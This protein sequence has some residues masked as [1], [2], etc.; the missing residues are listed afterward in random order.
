MYDCETTLVLLLCGWFR[1]FGLMII[2][3][4]VYG[5]L[6]DSFGWFGCRVCLL[7]G[8]WIRVFWMLVLM[9]LLCIVI[10]L[11]LYGFVA[12]GGFV[13]GCV[14]FTVIVYVVC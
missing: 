8:C 10:A 7:Y 4:G 9:R 1:Q 2:R 3:C 12:D 6:F 14:L 5:L 13:G 11:R